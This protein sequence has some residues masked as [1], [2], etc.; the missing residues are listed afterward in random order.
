[1]TAQNEEKLRRA[2]DDVLTACWTEDVPVLDAI[3]ESIEEWIALASAEFNQS[4]PFSDEADI[5]RL[6]AAIATLE[7][8]AHTTFV[9]GVPNPISG[10]LAQALADWTTNFGRP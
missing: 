6:A 8:A 2:L 4:E 7:G 1:M 3:A 9:G 10:V 5:S